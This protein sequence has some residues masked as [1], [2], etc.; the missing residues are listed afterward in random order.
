MI[1]EQVISLVGFVVM[2]IGAIEVRI[3]QVVS[4]SAAIQNERHAAL[5]HAVDRLNSTV[6]QLN[7]Y[8]HDVG[9]ALAEFKGRVRAIERE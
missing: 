5:G 4:S 9:S 1:G 3:R 8:V 2:L 6:A 7:E